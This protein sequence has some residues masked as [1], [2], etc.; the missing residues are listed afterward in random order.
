[1][2]VWRENTVFVVVSDHV[3]LEVLRK[4]GVVI[5]VDVKIGKIHAL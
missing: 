3:W 1:M 4:I 5:L 2:C